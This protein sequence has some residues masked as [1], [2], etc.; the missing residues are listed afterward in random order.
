LSDL[1]AGHV[2]RR[3]LFLWQLVTSRPPAA[4]TPF[5][6]LVEADRT[7][8]GQQPD[9]RSEFASY[10]HCASAQEQ[11]KIHPPVALHIGAPRFQPYRGVGTVNRLNASVL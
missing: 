5:A 9:S 11:T 10:E 4:G 7:G 6:S 8:G 2:R 1:V 3:G